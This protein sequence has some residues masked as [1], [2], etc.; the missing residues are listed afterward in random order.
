[1]SIRMHRAPKILVFDS[2]LGGLTVFEHVLA[3]RPHAD[4]VY[5]ADDEGFPYGPLT[6]KA[7]VARVLSVLE[8][9]IERCAPDIVVIACNT[10]ST[11]V[12]P[13]LRAR[14]P[15][16]PFVG[17]VPA[18]KPAAERSRSRLISVLATPGTVAR[19]YTRALI[20][21]FANGCEVTLVGSKRLASL[22]EEHMRGGE[23]A[24]ADVA[25]EIAPCFVT[26]AGGARTD[27]IALA[28]THYPLL[29]DVFE[30]VAP[31]PVEWIDPAPAIARQAD[32]LL[33]ERFGP[34]RE[35]SSAEPQRR[36]IFTSGARPEP[37]LAAALARFGLEPS[38]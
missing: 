34:D 16:I 18:I 20:E 13:H 21:S 24:D 12:L 25:G 10:A 11:E 31:W 14:W 4:L 26:N 19:D 27:A 28:C 32:R 36:A 9:M 35:A 37:A 3:A 38:S 5:C 22:A 2:G 17:T 15:Q 29:I 7:L 8:R 30:R 23:I 1:M 6:E 33:T